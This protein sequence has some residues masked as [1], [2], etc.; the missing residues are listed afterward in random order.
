MRRSAVNGPFSGRSRYLIPIREWKK[1]FC[2]RITAFMAQWIGS[3]EFPSNRWRYPDA[4]RSEILGL[5]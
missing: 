4:G 1:L 2:S 5:N 3:F